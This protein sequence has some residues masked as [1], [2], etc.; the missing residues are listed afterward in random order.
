MLPAGRSQTMHPRPSVLDDSIRNDGSTPF[1]Y[2]ATPYANN[3][4]LIPLTGRTTIIPRDVASREATPNP[5]QPETEPHLGRRSRFH[6][7]ENLFFEPIPLIP[8]SRRDSVNTSTSGRTD[9]CTPSLESFSINQSPFTLRNSSSDATI[10][11]SLSSHSPFPSSRSTPE[12]AE[13]FLSPSNVS[14]RVLSRLSLSRSTSNLRL[15]STAVPISR[16]VPSPLPPIN[17]ESAVSRST[18][19]N[20]G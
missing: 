17:R 14:G 19:Q 6:H 18:N 11:S 13:G 15:H 8:I 10:R 9:S 16:F 5:D 1:T 4:Q 2:R 20:D 3:A 7:Q 12:N